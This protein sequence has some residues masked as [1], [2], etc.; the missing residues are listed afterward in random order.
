MA[1][2]AHTRSRTKTDSMLNP[3]DSAFPGHG[4]SDRK[5]GNY[6]STASVEH[7]HVPRHENQY[8]HHLRG[9]QSSSIALI[10]SWLTSLANLGVVTGF[11]VHGDERYAPFKFDGET[12]PLS[13]LL[14]VQRRGVGCI[15]SSGTLFEQPEMRQSRWTG[16][17]LGEASL[18]LE[19]CTTLQGSQGEV[20]DSRRVRTRWRGGR[21][22]RGCAIVHCIED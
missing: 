12:I 4:Q 11:G 18:Q 5:D 17:G 7:D 20:E 19:D 16:F 9:L 1:E 21:R 8:A 6:G 3:Q 15:T 14:P 13:N 2:A 22:A 10:S